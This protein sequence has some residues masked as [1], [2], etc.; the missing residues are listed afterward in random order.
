[1]VGVKISPQTHA[2]P[3]GYAVW[4]LFC[5]VMVFADLKEKTEETAQNF[6]SLGSN[7]SELNSSTAETQRQLSY[8]GEV[9]QG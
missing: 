4:W 9:I 7:V 6:Q 8:Q 2:S 5:I 1:M 3:S